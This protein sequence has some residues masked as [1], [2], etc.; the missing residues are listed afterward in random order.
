MRVKIFTVI[1]LTAIILLGFFLVKS[2]AA[3]CCSD[4]CCCKAK[5]GKILDSYGCVCQG[6]SMIAQFCNYIDEPQQ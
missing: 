6:G 2:L 1:V 5:A 4:P 3:D